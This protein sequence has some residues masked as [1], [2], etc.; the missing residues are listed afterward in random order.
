MPLNSSG[1]ISL[2]GTTVGQSVNLELGRA[3]NAPIN[4]NESEVRLLFGVPTGQIRMSDGY[5]K[6]IGASCIIASCVSLA[7]GGV[8]PNIIAIPAQVAKYSFATDTL[9]FTGFSTNPGP[10]AFVTV[11]SGLAGY[12]STRQPG[13]T[14]LSVPV[15]KKFNFATCVTN[16]YSPGRGADSPTIKQG[17]LFES[18]GTHSPTRGYY[19][20]GINSPNTTIAIDGIIFSTDTLFNPSVNLVQSRNGARGLTACLQS[21]GYYAGGNNTNPPSNKFTQIDSISFTTQ[22]VSDTAASLPWGKSRQAAAAY[23]CANKGYLMYGN[24]GPGFTAPWSEQCAP[25]RVDMINYSTE[26]LSNPVTSPG[27]ETSF[28]GYSA[29]KGIASTGQNANPGPPA[30]GAWCAVTR[31]FGF[32]TETFANLGIAIPA[33]PKGYVPSGS[34]GGVMNMCGF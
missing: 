4:M 13:P 34:A 7:D 29:S 14:A 9:Q 23:H 10:G 25:I 20:G 1:V 31:S 12:S 2:G 8:T 11:S 18:N 26:A 33:Y 27:F 30:A 15:G 6:S 28:S 21:R 16:Y 17:S 3:S 19:G 32:A 5:G 22:T 24:G